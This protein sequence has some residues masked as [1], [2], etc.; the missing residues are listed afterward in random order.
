MRAIP[1]LLFLLTGTALAAQAHDGTD[2]LHRA[3]ASMPEIVLTSPNAMQVSFLDVQAWRGLSGGEASAPAMRRLSIAGGIAPLDALNYGG[4][5]SWEEKAG[6]AFDKIGYFAGFGQPPMAIGYWGFD[7]SD[8]ASQLIDNLR[9]RDFAPVAGPV[10]GTLG[11]G[12][13]NV[14]NLQNRDPANPWVGP[15]GRSSFALALDDVVIQAP[16]P[17]AMAAMTRNEPSA[18]DHDVLAAALD[19]LSGTVGVDQGQIIQAAIISPAFGLEGFDPAALF[20]TTNIEDAK[21]ALE[22]SMEEGVQGIPPYVG[23]ILADVQYEDGP[24]VSVSLIYADCEAADSAIAAL[25]AR[26]VENMTEVARIE[27]KS[28]AGDGA[29]CAA[30]MSFVGEDPGDAGNPLLTETLHRYMS[31]DFNLLRIGTAS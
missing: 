24:A 18:V 11:N 28:V 2:V 8:A 27:G 6:I 1:L 3:L 14:T 7:S 29:L 26:W 20:E 16:A 19:G 21:A 23:G 30:V 12:E 17:E 9:Q 31:R 22:A 13:P 4:L 15:L 5:D 10:E 25:K